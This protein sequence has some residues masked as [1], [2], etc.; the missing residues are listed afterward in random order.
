M[1]T[2]NPEP[3]PAEFAPDHFWAMATAIIEGP[4]QP[5]LNQCLVVMRQGI[6]DNFNS[7]ATPDNENWPPRKIVGDGHPL[8]MDTGA[9]LQAAV[10][11]GTGAI[12][13]VGTHE[14]TTGVDGGAIP[15]AAAQNF[16]RP[17]INL[18][19]R[20]F[21]GAREERIDEMEELIAGFVIE[22]LLGQ[23]A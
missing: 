14:A 16:G 18:P 8:L 7:S 15:Y 19:D 21:L 1:A 13:E 23:G 12:T 4:Y 17:E 11:S 20:E 9:M 6:R 5:A 3:I 22:T 10:G 2:V